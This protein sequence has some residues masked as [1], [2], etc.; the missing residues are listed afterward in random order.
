MKW[1]SGGGLLPMALGLG[2]HSESRAPLANA[3]IWGM[4]SA[5]TLTLLII[6]SVCTIVVDDIAIPMRRRIRFVLNLPEADY[7][8]E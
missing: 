1:S 7:Q 4:I 6:P 2:G 8:P 5:T 3:I